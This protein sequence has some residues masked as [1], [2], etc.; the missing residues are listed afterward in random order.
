MSDLS[1]FIRFSLLPLELRITIWELT[2]FA[3]VFSLIPHAYKWSEDAAVDTT[4]VPWHFICPRS[5]SNRPSREPNK[6]FSA[7]FTISDIVAHR[8][9]QVCRESRTLVFNRG[10]RVWKVQNKQG[11]VRNVVWNPAVDVI[12]FPS[13]LLETRIVP[14]SLPLRVHEKYYLPLFF[15][16]YPEET[17]IASR[18]AMYSSLALRSRPTGGIR[19]GWETDIAKFYS[20]NEFIMVVDEEAERTIVKRLIRDNKNLLSLP[21]GPWKLPQDLEDVF[22]QGK[23]HR[24]DTILRIPTVRVVENI[25]RIVDGQSLQISL[26]CNPCQYLGMG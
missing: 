18:L 11:K 17:K 12:L 1:S 3:Q 14:S 21:L 10:Y 20:L 26:H 23:L 22:I 6:I 24:P 16:Q 25:E 7:R 5:V 4:T 8:V 2:L 15:L 9:L 13:V 19:W